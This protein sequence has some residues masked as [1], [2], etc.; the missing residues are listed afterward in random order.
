MLLPVDKGLVVLHLTKVL[1]L[2]SGVFIRG[3]Q[4]LLCY[5]LH[6][7]GTASFPKKVEIFSWQIATVL[8]LLEVKLFNGSKVF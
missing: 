3:D 5:S 6:T 8:S 2:Q 7:Q 4:I 1:T